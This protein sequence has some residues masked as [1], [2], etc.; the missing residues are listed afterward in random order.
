[1]DSEAVNPTA[2]HNL[3]GLH[4]CLAENALVPRSIPCVGQGRNVPTSVAALSKHYS[5]R[6]LP[7]FSPPKGTREGVIGNDTRF[8]GA[9]AARR[10]QIPRIWRPT[11]EIRFLSRI[12][13]HLRKFPASSGPARTHPPHEAK[14]NKGCGGPHKNEA[15]DRR[16]TP[17]V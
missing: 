1:M 13:T 12:L 3:P 2:M 4:S 7:A 6:I 10:D 8:P 5:L 14:E 15:E 17:R 9:I 11:C 16:R